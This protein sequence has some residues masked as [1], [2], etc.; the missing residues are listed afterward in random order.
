MMSLNFVAKATT[1]KCDMN[2][3]TKFMH[4]VK[5]EFPN[6]AIMNGT[7]EMHPS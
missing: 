6:A 7:I 3:I 1:W 2:F 5:I 4:L